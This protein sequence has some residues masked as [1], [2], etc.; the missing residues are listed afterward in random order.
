METILR[1]NAGRLPARCAFLYRRSVCRGCGVGADGARLD[2]RGAGR[3]DAG[4]GAADKTF[5]VATPASAIHRRRFD[6][7]VPHDARELAHGIG[8]A[9]PREDEVAD[10]AAVGL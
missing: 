5:S 6:R 2:Q 7:A 3:R 9:C 8:A 4:A 10:A 1:T